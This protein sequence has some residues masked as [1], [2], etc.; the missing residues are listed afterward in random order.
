VTAS[1]LQR[2]HF[3]N[4]GRGWLQSGFLGSACIFSSVLFSYFSLMMTVAKEIT[5]F[6]EA[7]TTAGR[8]ECRPAFF[9]AQRPVTSPLLISSLLPPPQTVNLHLAQSRPRRGRQG[10]LI[11]LFSSQKRA[12]IRTHAAFWGFLTP[13]FSLTR[14]TSKPILKKVA[15]HTTLVRNKYSNHLN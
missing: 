14:F 8:S 3:T 15:F 7:L 10:Y 12:A 9:N 4:R 6:Q 13:L 1:S 5:A 2:L 11:D